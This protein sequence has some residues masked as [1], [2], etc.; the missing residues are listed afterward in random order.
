MQ[1]H[2]KYMIL[3][4]LMLTGCYEISPVRTKEVIVVEGWIEAGRYPIVMLT[5]NVPVSKEGQ[6]I[7]S[8]EQY[9]I[10]W[11]KVTISDGKEEVILTGRM[12]KDYFPPYIYTTSRMK[13]E[14]GRTYDIVIEYSGKVVTASTTIPAPVE[15]KYLD[16]MR[17]SDSDSLFILK[18]GLK[19]NPAT[20]DYYKFFTK[21][22]GTDTYY[23]APVPG[24]INDAVLSDSI[25]EIS[26]MKG[27]G[28]PETD[29][30][31]YFCKGDTVDVKVC[32]MDQVSYSYWTDFEE[33]LSLSANPFFT[34]TQ[35]I[36]T[37]VNNGLGYWA[38]YGSTYYTT[39]IEP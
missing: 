37:N 36:R 21:V 4:V 23:K 35:K 14:V 28:L 20:K 1:S 7:D 30:S 2:L 24:T 34:S 27:L 6:S 9:L 25:A 32:T 38:G 11:A 3:V 33:I 22:R 8:L 5:T 10:R 19:D 31:M 26:V 18:A 12:D 15:L 39:V 13:G 17:H 16:V 29:G